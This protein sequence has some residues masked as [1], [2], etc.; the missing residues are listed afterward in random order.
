M[1]NVEF[2]SLKRKDNPLSPKLAK[3]IEN[4]EKDFIALLGAGAKHKK[5]ETVRQWLAR[6]VDA[7]IAA[8]KVEQK[9]AAW[10]IKYKNLLKNYARSKRDSKKINWRTG[11][12]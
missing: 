6:N 12:F 1:K 7:S 9:M 10:I 8:E 2:E 3:N 4:L 5:G 11:A